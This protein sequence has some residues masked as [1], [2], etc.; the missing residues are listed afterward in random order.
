MYICGNIDPIMFEFPILIIW[1]QG[2]IEWVYISLYSITA[3][4]N[5]SFLLGYMDIF[6]Y[7]IGSMRMNFSLNF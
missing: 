6:L 7:S 4:E 3:V 1:E 2:N 5:L